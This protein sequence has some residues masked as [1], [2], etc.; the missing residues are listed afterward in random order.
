MLWDEV[1]DRRRSWRSEFVER[2]QAMSR[3]RRLQLAAIVM[4]R[5]FDAVPDIAGETIGF[6]WP[7]KGELDMR[8][9]IATCLMA[10]AKAAAL[11][12]IVEKN[13]PV[14]F[15]TW[16]PD[17]AMTTGFWNIPIP[18]NGEP[19]QP[20]ILLVPLVGFDLHC[21]RLGYGGGYYDRTLAAS[22]PQPLAIG[23]GY[24]FSSLP[25]IFPQRHDIA[26][27]VIV[28]ET[29]LRWRESAAIDSVR[30]ALMRGRRR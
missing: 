30:P 7:I 1:R 29:T 27:D 10:G 11:P 24:E 23:V 18:A 28:T 3:E 26:M 15:R 2:R 22:S 19:V 21:Y 6:Y 5:L 25:S 8:E 4:E 14:E 9:F 17:C 20:T 13:K 12:V 16:S